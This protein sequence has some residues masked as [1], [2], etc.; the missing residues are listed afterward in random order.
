MLSLEDIF[1]IH[2]ENDTITQNK[3][4]RK[5]DYFSAN[6]L[7]HLSFS[8]NHLFFDINATTSTWHDAFKLMSAPFVELGNISTKY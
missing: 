7:S 2:S 3:H 1:S 5:K 4:F 6:P 8:V